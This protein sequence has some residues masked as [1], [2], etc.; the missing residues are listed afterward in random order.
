M[1]WCQKCAVS[2]KNVQHKNARHGA[3]NV[4]LVPKMCGIVPKM[5]GMVPKMYGMVPKMCGMV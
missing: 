5:C 1:A 3:K 4:W 2:A